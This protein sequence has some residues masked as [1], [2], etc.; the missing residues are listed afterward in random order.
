MR[1]WEQ[2]EFIAGSLDAIAALSKHGFKLVVISNQSG[3]GR[4]FVA[5]EVVDEIHNKMLAEISRSGGTIAGLYYC[6][7]TPEDNCTCRKPRTGMLVQ[8][9]RELQ[10]ELAKSYLVGDALDDVTTGQKMGC[11]TLLV[12]TGRGREEIRRL[13]SF[14][15]DQPTVVD[16]LLAAANW[17][18][19]REA[20][21]VDSDRIR[22]EPDSGPGTPPSGSVPGPKAG[23]G[24]HG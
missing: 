11:T 9:A 16:D 2:F 6:P 12:R 10:L 7:H 17:I 14:E 8:A 22:T 15:G 18:L 20:S 23:P 5:R 21:G 19:A 24:A 13:P 3:I 4:H 1:A